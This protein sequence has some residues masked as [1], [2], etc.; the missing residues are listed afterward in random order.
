MRHE[1]TNQR[2]RSKVRGMP[3]KMVFHFETSPPEHRV[4]L[5][6]IKPTSGNKQ[7][8]CKHFSH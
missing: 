5:R 6:G 4:G 8:Q 7:P 3:L 2:P 1:K